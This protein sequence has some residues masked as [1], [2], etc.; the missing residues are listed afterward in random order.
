MVYLP[1]RQVMLLATAYY[2]YYYLPGHPNTVGRLDPVRGIPQPPTH[3]SHPP[4][5]KRG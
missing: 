3:L 5:K 1:S 2:L 4:Q